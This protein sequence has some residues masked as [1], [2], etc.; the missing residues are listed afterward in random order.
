MS[1]PAISYAVAHDEKGFALV[2]VSCL[3]DSVVILTSLL[4]SLTLGGGC[5]VTR[6]L[7][8]HVALLVD[9]ERFESIDLAKCVP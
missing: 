8:R 5:L 1:L 2:A 7:P 4:L 9:G 6:D 3:P